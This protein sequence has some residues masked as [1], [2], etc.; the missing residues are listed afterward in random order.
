MPPAPRTAARSL[1]GGLPPGDRPDLAAQTRRLGACRRAVVLSGLAERVVDGP[2]RDDER[3]RRPARER[4][5][6]ICGPGALRADPREEQHRLR[7]QL[8]RLRDGARVRRADYRADRGEAAL[9]DDVSAPLGDEPCDVVPERTAVG[10]RHVLHVAAGVRGLDDAEDAGA[11][12]P[13]GS[14]ER[15]DRLAPEV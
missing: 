14:E 1:R 5:G 9:A 15:L 11:F 7:H 2:G 13:G 4:A 10:E 8:A 6:E 3:A 12:T